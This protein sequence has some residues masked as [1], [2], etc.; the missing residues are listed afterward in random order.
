MPQ[1]TLCDIKDVKTVPILELMQALADHERYVA[2]GKTRYLK[3]VEE[4]SYKI[5]AELTRRDKL[6]NPEID[7]F[8]VL[9]ET[10]ASVAPRAH[11][12]IGDTLGAVCKRVNAHIKK[13]ESLRGTVQKTQVMRLADWVEHNTYQF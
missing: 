5:R 6:A 3:L 7:H 4:D 1:L 10:T 9:I 2:Q 8:V 11:V 12:T 13:D